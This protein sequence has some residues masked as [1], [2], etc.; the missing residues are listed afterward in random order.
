[1]LPSADDDFQAGITDL[2]GQPDLL[3]ALTA[4]ACSLALLQ[5]L[6][7]AR[8]TSS[9]SKV[10]DS[11]VEPAGACPGSGGRPPGPRQA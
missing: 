8:H 2:H 10:S 3:A 6:A 4:Y 7:S 1:V 11:G 9:R 5:A